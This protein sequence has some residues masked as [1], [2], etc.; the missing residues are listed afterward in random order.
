MQM[1]QAFTS[2]LVKYCNRT[3]K[4]IL[5]VILACNI[6]GAFAI[7]WSTS[8][9][10][11]QGP[12]NVSSSDDVKLPANVTIKINGNLTIQKKGWGANPGGKLTIEGTLWITGNLSLETNTTLEMKPGSVLIVGKNAT[13]ADVFI[14]DNLSHFIANDALIIINGNYNVGSSFLGAES[15]LDPSQNE[16]YVLGNSDVS[17]TLGPTDFS[18]KYESFQT[19]FLP[20]EL[21][22]FSIFATADGFMFNWIT[23]SENENDYFTLEYSIDGVSFNEIDYVHGAGTTS[24]TSEYEYRWDE[25]PDFEMLYFRLKQTDYNGEFSYSDV[26]VSSRKKSSGANGTFRYGPLNLQIQDGELRYIQK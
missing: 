2:S 14:R 25:A 4:A 23:A 13:Q 22:S 3:L 21:T 12:V 17:G 1:K 19:V 5:L 9:N 7:D 18:V 8:N 15:A 20:I 16:V 6:S 11:V 24:E 10:N 26:L